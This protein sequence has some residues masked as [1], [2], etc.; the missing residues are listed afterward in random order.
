MKERREYY[1][2]PSAILLEIMPEGEDEK[3]K[4]FITNLGERGLAFESYKRLTLNQKMRLSFTLPDGFWLGT[5]NP[6]LYCK[7]KGEGAVWNMGS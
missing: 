5:V 3:Y 6:D 4:G 1:R 7:S 2:I